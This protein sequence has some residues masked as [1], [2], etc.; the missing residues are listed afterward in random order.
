MKEISK[1]MPENQKGRER[2]KDDEVPYP[3]S[4]PTSLC[5]KAITPIPVDNKPFRN[6][7]KNPAIKANNTKH[8][9]KS[10]KMFKMRYVLVLM[11]TIML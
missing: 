4:L 11:K 7:D 3:A 8:Y 2:K 1:G 10:N 6:H 9:R 5:T